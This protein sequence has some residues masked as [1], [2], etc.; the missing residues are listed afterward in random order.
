MGF[1]TCL[2]FLGGLAGALLAGLRLAGARLAGALLAGLRLVGARFAEGR[3]P[4]FLGGML[5]LLVK[6]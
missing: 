2:G 5:R 4:L 3:P 1:F 6:I